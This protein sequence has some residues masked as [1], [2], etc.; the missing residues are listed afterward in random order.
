MVNWN[1]SIVSGVLIYQVIRQKG[2]TSALLVYQEIRREGK[3]I[4]EGGGGRGKKSAER[5]AIPE[6]RKCRDTQRV[7]R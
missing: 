4:S 3:T 7:I 2:F 1:F 5:R 6:I